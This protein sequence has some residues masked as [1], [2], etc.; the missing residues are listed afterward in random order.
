MKK[1]ARSVEAGWLENPAAPQERQTAAWLGTPPPCTH[2]PLQK[3]NNPFRVGCATLN[4]C[5]ACHSRQAGGQGARAAHLTP[6]NLHSTRETRETHPLQRREVRSGIDSPEH[7]AAQEEAALGARAS[8][9]P[10]SL[11]TPCW[12]SSPV[13]H[14]APWL[15]GASCSMGSGAGCPSQSGGSNLEVGAAEVCPTGT[16]PCPAPSPLPGDSWHALWGHL[17]PACAAD[18]SD[19]VPARLKG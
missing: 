9:A 19:P 14:A 6:G 16:S 11:R 3:R 7:P 10:G 2:Y 5:T 17:V 12:D 8:G 1:A 4:C 15:S 18:S 13:T